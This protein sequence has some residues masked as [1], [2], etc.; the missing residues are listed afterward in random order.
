ME[1]DGAPFTPSLCQCSILRVFKATATQIRE[2]SE[3][4]LVLLRIELGT[5][6]TEGCALTNCAT[7]MLLNLQM[8][9]NG[10]YEY[11]GRIQGEYPIYLPDSFL[12]TAE[13]VKRAHHTTLHGD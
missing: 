11:R 3:Q 8:N 5:F 6:R 4:T 7:R 1:A 12:F 9:A 13:V 10:I 2:K